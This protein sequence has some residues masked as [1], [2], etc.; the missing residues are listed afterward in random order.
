MSKIGRSGELEQF[1]VSCPM[2]P[3][4]GAHFTLSIMAIH[5]ERT[6]KMIEKIGLL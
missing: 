1:E 5:Y 6:K 4:A 2:Q 3:G